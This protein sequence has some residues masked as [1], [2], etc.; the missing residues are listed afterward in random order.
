MKFSTL[1]LLPISLS[2]FFLGCGTE[3]NEPPLVPEILKIEINDYNTTANAYALYVENEIPKTEMHINVFY[4]DDTEATATEDLDWVSLDGSDISQD[5]LVTNGEI[6]AFRNHGDANV[7]ATFREKFKTPARHVHIIPLTK[8][9]SVTAQTDANT[10]ELTPS[11][12]LNI[13]VPT[14]ESIK[15]LADGQFE[16]EKNITTINQS[17]I[18]TSSNYDVATINSITGQMNVIKTGAVDINVSVYNEVNA[19]VTLNITIK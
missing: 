11:T 13:S 14:G 19:T 8:I 2:L 10:S 6:T 16:D 12:E 3:S 1:T 9:L 4:S 15:M 17:I 7:T 18:W 5:I